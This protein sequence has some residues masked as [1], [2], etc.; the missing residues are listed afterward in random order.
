MKRAIICLLLCGVGFTYISAQTFN[1]TGIELKNEKVKKKNVYEWE[2]F[3]LANYAFGPGQHAFGLTYGQVKLFG[4]YTN[5]MFGTGVHW[6]HQYEG[7]PSI[8]LPNGN[9]VYPFYNGNTSANQLEITAGGIVRLVIP[10]YIYFGTGFGYR[11]LTCQTTDGEWVKM[12]GYYNGKNNSVGP[13]QEWA[14]GLQGNIKGFTIAAG[15]SI[16]TNYN[17]FMPEVKVGLGYTFKVK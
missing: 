8:T 16:I 11:T 9:R 6:I 1:Y 15:A 14:L 13:G 12:T 5:V 3:I 7:D 4:W 2:Q 17:A 10:L